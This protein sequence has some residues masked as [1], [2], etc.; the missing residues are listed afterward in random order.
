MKEVESSRRFYE[1][2]AFR[3]LSQIER[4][5]TEH[6]LYALENVYYGA[7]LLADH[8]FSLLNFSLGK[9]RSVTHSPHLGQY[10]IIPLPS[11]YSLS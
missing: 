8:Y 1:K 11:F 3:S 7:T 2:W 10:A 9:F 5:E 6:S 4:N